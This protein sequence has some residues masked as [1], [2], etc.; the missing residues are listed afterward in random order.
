M[1]GVLPSRPTAAQIRLRLFFTTSTS[2]G[3][4]ATAG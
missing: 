4:E 2:T 3:G 1:R